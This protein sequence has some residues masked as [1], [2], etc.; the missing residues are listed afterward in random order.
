MRIFRWR[1]DR[2]GPAFGKVRK[3]GNTRQVRICRIDEKIGLEISDDA[4]RIPDFHGQGRMDLPP[5]QPVGYHV[6]TVSRSGHVVAPCCARAVDR[7]S[8]T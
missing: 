5:S 1:L 4:G 2:F 8:L 7:T 6:G 3:L